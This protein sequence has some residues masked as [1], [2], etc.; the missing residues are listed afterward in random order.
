VKKVIFQM[1]TICKKHSK[2]VFKISCKLYG[3]QQL[4]FIFSI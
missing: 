3:Y 2:P 4:L 1:Y